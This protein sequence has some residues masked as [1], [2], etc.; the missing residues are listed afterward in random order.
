M[1]K[2]FEY[3]REILIILITIL[4][5]FLITLVIN[6]NNDTNSN[7][8]FEEK[9]YEI[10][11]IMNS[12]PKNINYSYNNVNFYVP[13]HYQVIEEDSLILKNETNYFQIYFD[14]TEYQSEEKKYSI[15]KDLKLLYESNFHPVENENVNYYVWEQNKDYYEIM[16]T[17][18]NSYIVGDINKKDIKSKINDMADIL[19]SA[20]YIEETNDSN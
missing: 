5:L 9:G 14:N 18:N 6:L 12:K 15:N 17:D 19:N 4:L 10:N 1:N 8:K 13:A 16:I 11:Q 20:Q 2:Y 3:K 7:A